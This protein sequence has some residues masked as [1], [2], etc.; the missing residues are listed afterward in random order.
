MSARVELEELLWAS[1]DA[2]LCP[3]DMG[4]KWVYTPRD[5][6]RIGMNIMHQELLW[7]SW[8]RAVWGYKWNLVRFLACLE[9][10]TVVGKAC[11]FPAGIPTAGWVGE[12]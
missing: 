6:H 11:T 7:L 1:Q 4:G 8:E 9:E 5:Y 3:E 10:L 12:Y 2:D